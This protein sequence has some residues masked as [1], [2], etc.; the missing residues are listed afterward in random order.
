MNEQERIDHFEQFVREGLQRGMSRRELLRQGLSLGLGFPAV[1]GILA[2]CG[3]EPRP[4]AAP[5][6]LPTAVIR[7]PTSEAAA[8]A[9]VPP[10]ATGAPTAVPPTATPEPTPVPPSPT[11]P[12]LTRFAVIGDY[13]LA[14]EPA[15]A[16]AVLVKSWLPDFVLT[17]G[18]NNYPVGSAESL[19]RNVG[20]YYHE[21]IAPYKG[22]YGPGAASNRFFPVLGNHDWDQ[23]NVDAYLDYFTLPGIGRYYD[24]SWGAAHFFCLDSFFA[25]PDGYHADSIQAEWLRNAL[26]GSAAPWKIVVLHHSPYSSGLHGPMKW[27]RWPYKEWG[28]D[29]VLSGHDHDYERLEVDGLTYVVNGLGGGARYAPGSTAMVE[30]R[31]FF[32]GNHGAMLIELDPGSL[33][34]QFITRGGEIIDSFALK[35]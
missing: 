17:T 23:G 7:A 34:A 18:D 26:A 25:E 11:P 15:G 2:A 31:I 35:R 6:D 14:G 30:S 8:P 1:V 29:L 24:F 28:A 13:G 9:A 16:V 20:Q 5:A 33:Q 4:Q 12:P 21:F 22:S 27:M 32:N 10:T 3:I 19:D